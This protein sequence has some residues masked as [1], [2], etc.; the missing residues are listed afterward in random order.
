MKLYTAA[1]S[2]DPS[3]GTYY[4]NRASCWMAMQQYQRAVDD[5]TTGLRFDKAGE[6]GKL[7][8]RQATALVHL[9]KAR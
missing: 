4:G 6:L 2:S 5:C 3:C 1:I 9:G 8:G 7:R